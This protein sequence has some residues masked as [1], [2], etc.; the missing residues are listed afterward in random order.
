MI[1]N[2]KTDLIQLLKTIDISFGNTSYSCDD[3]NILILADILSGERASFRAISKNHDVTFERVRQILQKG[4]YKI[5]LKLQ[6]QQKQIEYLTSYIQELNNNIAVSDIYEL[7]ILEPM[8]TRLKNIL[9]E[10]RLNTID[11]IMSYQ[12]RGSIG[13][14]ALY[15]MPKMGKLTFNEL[16]D[17]LK[18][19]C[20]V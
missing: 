16:A 10:N 18:K 2:N 6:A 5:G 11:D 7:S 1:N 15:Y 8:S 17:K 13:L 14:D 20:L 12:A 19:L 3:R 4:I 9:Y